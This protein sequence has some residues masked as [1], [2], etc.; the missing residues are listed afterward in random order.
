MPFMFFDLDNCS[1]QLKTIQLR[2][3]F[4]KE[5]TVFLQVNQKIILENSLKIF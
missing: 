2:F 4:K 1:Y 3:I 5:K